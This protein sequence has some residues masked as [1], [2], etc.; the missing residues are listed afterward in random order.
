MRCSWR[1]G[2]ATRDAGLFEFERTFLYAI[3][4]QERGIITVF[5]ANGSLEAMGFGLHVFADVKLQPG[6]S[7]KSFKQ[8]LQNIDVVRDAMSLTGSFDTRLR[9][10]STHRT[11]LG[12]LIESLPSVAAVPKARIAIICR[13]LDETGWLGL[14]RT[15]LKI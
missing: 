5:Q 10:T 15:A 11:H 6:A 9:V 1:F 7:M 4:N 14:A 8:A 12:Q 13:S 3:E 2:A